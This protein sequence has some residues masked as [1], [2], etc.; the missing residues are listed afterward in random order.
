[1]SDFGIRKGFSGPV[2]IGKR[3]GEGN[4]TPVCSLG[5]CR[6][7]IELHPRKNFRFSIA[8][9]RF[10]SRLAITATKSRRRRLFPSFYPPPAPERFATVYRFQTTS[11]LHLFEGALLQHSA[12]KD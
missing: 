5:S 7:T 4:R 10:E 6:S 8:D 3:A 12:R 11:R 2:F 1:M 9:L